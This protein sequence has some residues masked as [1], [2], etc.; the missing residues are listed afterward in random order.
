MN[1]FSVFYHCVM[2][3]DADLC[4]Q[5]LLTDPDSLKVTWFIIPVVWEMKVLYFCTV[6]IS[7]WKTIWLK[8]SPVAETQTK[9]NISKNKKQCKRHTLS[10]RLGL[11]LFFLIKLIVRAESG[12]PVSLVM[13]HYSWAAGG[14]SVIHWVFLLYTS[15]FT[16]CGFIHHSVL[17]QSFADMVTVGVS[18][19]YFRTFTLQ[20]K[21]LEVTVVKWQYI[22]W[23]EKNDDLV[24]KVVVVNGICTK[25]IFRYF[26]IKNYVAIR[27]QYFSCLSNHFV[28]SLLKHIKPSCCIHIFLNSE[29]LD[30]NF[31]TFGLND[32][33]YLHWL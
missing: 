18:F 3:L 11:K 12:D 15:L 20:D 9:Y 22:K 28:K 1:F 13:L 24:N 10:L 32:I 31:V 2:S 8:S 6:L 21:A 27:L 29:I 23:I 30:L 16:P 33:K 7:L 4:S 25:K 19:K 14:T 5:F 17:N 26:D